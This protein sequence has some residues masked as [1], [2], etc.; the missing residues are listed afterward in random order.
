M[1][2]FPHRAGNYVLFAELGAG[3]VGA[4]YIGRQVG[5]LRGAFKPLIIRVLEPHLSHRPD[6]VRLFLDEQRTAALL[7]HP[8][9]AAVLEVGVMPD[10]NYFMAAEYVHGVPLREVLR[11]PQCQLT[12][13]Q[14]VHLAMQL[15]DALHYA[16]ERLDV[17]GRPLG[18]LHGQLTPDAVIVGFDGN[19]K[20]T[21]FGLLR[22]RDAASATIPTLLQRRTAFLSPELRAQLPLRAAPAVD[23]RTDIYSIGALLWEMLTGE[24]LVPAE[25]GSPPP[26]VSRVRHVDE[27]LDAI[28]TRALSR[29]PA[30]RFP[31]ALSM[32]L[33]L[34]GVAASLAAEGLV[35]AG[36]ARGLTVAFRE[37]IV[38]FQ[39]QFDVW[40][41]FEDDVLPEGHEPSRS[42]VSM[43]GVG[44]IP[45]GM[46]PAVSGIGPF[47]GSSQSQSGIRNPAS[48][49]GIRNPASQSGIRNVSG[50]LSSPSLTPI[51]SPTPANGAGVRGRIYSVLLVVAILGI[52]AGGLLL[53][54][55]PRPPMQ[56]ALFVDSDP[57]GAEIRIDGRPTG[58]T[59]FRVSNLNL[60]AVR[61]EIRKSG[62]Q[63]W[64][65]E[66]TLQP[67]KTL[68]VEA[69]LLPE[70][71]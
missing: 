32:R 63:A 40:R 57:R 64:T 41:K 55:R 68:Q 15:C 30:D 48:Q 24:A 44:L 26:P 50:I 14:A 28:V 5:Y 9:I 23:R 46:G 35:A 19:V 52:L 12:T 47:S 38:A 42:S 17:T 65:R 8:R 21:E 70:G 22:T 13:G 33:A 3:T 66:V 34:T 29:S 54:L 11:S 6:V 67:G 59:P 37:R 16:H 53:L 4:T 31:T 61:V 36:L 60:G 25:D 58:N 71:R 20:V 1:P 62:Y 27:A 43:S 39:E 18:I 49:S 2:H 45:S 69:E 56:G 10:G 51:P 7:Q